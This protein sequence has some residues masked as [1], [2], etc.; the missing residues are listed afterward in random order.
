[1]KTDWIAVNGAACRYADSGAGGQTVLLIHEL[2]GSLNSWDGLVKLLPAGL[3]VI[4]YDMR[5]AGMSEKV[6]GALAI[7]MLA[8]D[9][10]ALLD[11]LAIGDP[12]TVVGAAVGAAIATRFA[13]RHPARCAGLVL[14]APALGIPPERKGPASE[15]CDRIDREGLRQV[16]DAVLSKAFPEELWANEAE[17]ARAVARWLGADP[18][19][20]AAAYRMLIAAELADDLATINAPALVLAGRH[21]PF[22]TPEIV[23]QRTLAMKHRTFKILEGGH[24]LAVQSP[25]VLADALK[26]VLVA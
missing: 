21:D 20:Y 7:D 26:D 24:F 2:A 14:V 22:G 25:A 11:H 23:E 3:R 8:D 12:V 5:G 4:R 16:A 1:M 17:K 10:A 19:G 13:A 6:S 9:A 15:L 18:Q